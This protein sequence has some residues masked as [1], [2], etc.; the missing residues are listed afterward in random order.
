MVAWFPGP[1]GDA[2]RYLLRLRR[3]NQG[4]YT[5]H[6]KFYEPREESIGV[7]LMLSMDAASVSV[8]EGL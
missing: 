2:E 4:L 7:R 1:A 8:L 3:L 5:R 6:W